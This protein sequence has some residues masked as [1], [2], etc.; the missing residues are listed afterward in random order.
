MFKSIFNNAISVQGK[1]IVYSALL[2]ASSFLG[3]KAERQTRVNAKAD[4]GDLGLCG[5]LH[6]PVQFE[7]FHNGRLSGCSS[8]GGISFLTSPAK[9]V[10]LLLFHHC[11]DVLKG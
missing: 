8:A 1:G 10:F 7:W 6:D 2:W 3:I 9:L 4:K 5:D 11:K